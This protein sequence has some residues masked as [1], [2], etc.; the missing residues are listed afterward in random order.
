MCIQELPSLLDTAVGWFRGP[1]TLISLHQVARSKFGL[2]ADKRRWADVS[3]CSN[4]TEAEQVVFKA[5][6][7][8]DNCCGRNY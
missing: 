4:F 7:F 8:T 6:G 2:G 3:S 1:A 5:K